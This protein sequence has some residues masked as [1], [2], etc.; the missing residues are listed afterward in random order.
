M[1]LGYLDLPLAVE[2]APGTFVGSGHLL[3]LDQPRFT[4]R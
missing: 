1:V 4:P 3:V 2:E